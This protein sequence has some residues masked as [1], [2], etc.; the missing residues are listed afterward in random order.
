MTATIQ[1]NE[2]A[3]LKTGPAVTLSAEPLTIGSFPTGATVPHYVP[4]RLAAE[5]PDARAVVAARRRR[6]DVA[7]SPPVVRRSPGR[8]L[9]AVFAAGLVAGWSA[10]GADTSHARSTTDSRAAISTAT[11]TAPA[12]QQ[13]SPIG[14]LSPIDHWPPVSCDWTPLLYRKA[15][16]TRVS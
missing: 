15:C 8:L 2:H 3:P 12:S 16:H 7:V 14:Q 9:L 1:A 13:P 5:H 11:P 10:V 4:D 6:H